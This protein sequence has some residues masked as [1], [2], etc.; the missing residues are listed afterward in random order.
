MNINFDNQIAL[1]TGATRGIGKQIADDLLDAGAHVIV[2]GTSKKTLDLISDDFEKICVDF[3]DL[4]S[5]DNFINFISQQKID[6]C[7]NNAGI[8]KI[9]SLHEISMVIVTGKHKSFQN[10]H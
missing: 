5:V 2:T 4:N 3:L 7:I 8:N 6:I 1:V 9:N 10:H